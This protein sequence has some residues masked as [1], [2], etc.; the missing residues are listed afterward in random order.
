MHQGNTQDFK[1]NIV[2][3]APIAN[4]SGLAAGTTVM[5]LDGETPV[6]NLKVG[7]RIITRDTGMAVLR[8]IT[9]HEV[10]VAA[11]QIKARRIR[12]RTRRHPHD[13]I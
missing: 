12:I 1:D 9:K 10:H 11:I 5:T 13:S 2:V 3:A 4:V 7:S 8:S 6:E